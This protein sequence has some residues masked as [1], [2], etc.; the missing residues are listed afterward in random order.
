MGRSAA[1]EEGEKH[2]IR[3]KPGLR[4]VAEEKKVKAERPGLRQRELEL[5]VALEKI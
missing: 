2:Q 4:L 3:R 5:E 1:W